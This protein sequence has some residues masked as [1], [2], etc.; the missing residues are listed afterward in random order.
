M[1]KKISEKIANMDSLKLGSL[2]GSLLVLGGVLV[3][4]LTSTTSMKEVDEAVD[5]NSNDESE[6]K[7][8]TIE[9]DAE[10]VEVVEE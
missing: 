10:V 6:A 1:F 8:D 5:A 3:V 2:T 7:S 9:V 4:L